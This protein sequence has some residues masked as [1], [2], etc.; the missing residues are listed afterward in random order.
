MD[1][2]FHYYMTYLIA[3]R[4]GFPSEQ[5]LTIAHAA[6]SVDDNHIRYVISGSPD[7]P[8]NNYVSQTLNILKPAS[9]LLRIYPI[10]HFIPG[11]PN[12]PTARR[13]DG[14]TD[15]WVTTPDSAVAGK[16]I[17]NALASH[18]LYRI[19]VSAHGYVDTWAHQNFLGRRDAYNDIPGSSWVTSLLNVGHGSAGHQPDHPALVWRDPRLARPVVDNRQRFLDAAEA[20]FR[21]FVLHIDPAR[22][23]AML[24]SD[25]AS[26]RKDLDED[27]GPADPGNDAALLAA[28]LTRYQARALTAP[29]GAAPLPTYVEYFWFNAAVAEEGAWLRQK[30]DDALNVVDD[31]LDQ[32]TAIPC[33]WRDADGFEQSDWYQF[34]EA[35]KAHQN[36]CW[37]ILVAEGLPGLDVP[38]M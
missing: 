7:G 6:Q 23:A 13:A 38:N 8:Y 5:A 25:V 4:A 24:V 9:Q 31:Y 32:T 27:I 1:I 30:F 21:R 28:R 11:D 17:D 10:F 33:S 19:G 15:P 14:R 36:A 3:A 29:Y 12:A 26:L 34:V 2:E 18:N 35:V 22:N 37:D 20:L 16:M